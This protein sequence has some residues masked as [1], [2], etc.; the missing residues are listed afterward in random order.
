MLKDLGGSFNEKEKEALNN[1]PLIKKLKDKESILE[2]KIDYFEKEKEALIENDELNKRIIELL[3]K[4]GDIKF[5]SQ[6]LT[7]L[8]LKK[9]VE[10]QVERLEYLSKKIIEVVPESST[11]FGKNLVEELRLAKTGK[12]VAKNILVS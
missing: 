12:A 2:K 11:L 3:A 8:G 5:D 10:K 4:N 6:L 1:N 9:S 7:D